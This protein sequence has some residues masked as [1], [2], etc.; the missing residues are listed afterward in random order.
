MEKNPLNGKQPATNGPKM[1]SIYDT[2]GGMRAWLPIG[3]EGKE[4]RNQESGHDPEYQ[5]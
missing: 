4:Y 1:Y 5:I 3:L 2:L